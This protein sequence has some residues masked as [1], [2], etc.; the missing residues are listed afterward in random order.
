VNISSVAGSLPDIKETHEIN[1]LAM[2]ISNNLDR[3]S[4]FLDNDRLSS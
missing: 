1:I 2:E 3:W 4:D